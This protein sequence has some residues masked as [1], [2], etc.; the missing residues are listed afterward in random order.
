[1]AAQTTSHGHK[2][3]NRHRDLPVD[4]GSLMRIVLNP[5][6]PTLDWISFGLMLGAMISVVW[7]VQAANWATTPPLPVVLLIGFLVGVILA[8]LRS[9]WIVLQATALAA[10][11]A[12]FVLIFLRFLDIPVGFGGVEVIVERFGEWVHVARTGGISTDDLPF[13]VALVTL[14][15]LMG[16]LAGW[17]TS[18]TGAVWVPLVVAG[19][20]LLINLSYLP[21][22]AIS[23]FYLYLAF[24]MLAVA[25]AHYL[26]RRRWWE[27]QRIQR[28][29][30][31]GAYALNYAFWFG[32]IVM[33]LL[34]Y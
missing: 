31:S 6:R 12:T 8:K 26:A 17:Q 23:Y 18:R 10:W 20:G 28:P 1:M 15:W 22:E 30:L 25:W 2:L 13:A 21:P 29:S 19:I 3:E 5:F 34:S 27:R 14:S 9:H 4:G 24:A 32:L 16:Y 33:I 11:S 7:S